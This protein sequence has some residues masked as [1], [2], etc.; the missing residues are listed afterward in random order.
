MEW[1]NATPLYGQVPVKFAL[2]S[3]PA[4]VTV[5]LDGVKLHPALVGV[6]V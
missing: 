3:V 2:T 6:T 1:G 4:I 5:R